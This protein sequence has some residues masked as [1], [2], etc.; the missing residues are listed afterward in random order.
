MRFFG[1][2]FVIAGIF[3]VFFFPLIALPGIIIGAILISI[4]RNSKDRKLAKKARK[5][6]YKAEKARMEGDFETAKELELKAKNMT[7][8]I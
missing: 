7:E 1:W 6:R 3:S 8:G 2:L 4:G 5:L